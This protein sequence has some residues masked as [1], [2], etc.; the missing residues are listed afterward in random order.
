[1]EHA[2]VD[3]ADQA[4]QTQRRP[5]NTTTP[6]SIP[7]I[8]HQVAASPGE[9]LDPSTRAFMEPRFGHD[10][11]QV[12]VHTDARAAEAAHAVGALAYTTGSHVVFGAQQYAPTTHDGQRLIAHEL[13]HVV[14]QSRGPSSIQRS[15]IAPAGGR[16]E[17]EAREAASA[18]LA[19]QP[20][21]ALSAADA[22]QRQDAGPDAG[23][24]TGAP[25]D[26]GTTPDAGAT[27]APDAGAPAGPPDA[28][29]PGGTAPGAPGAPG[30]GAPPVAPPV[31]LTSLE[32]ENQRTSITY[33]TP[34]VLGAAGRDHYVTAASL[35]GPEAVVRA[36]VTPAVAASDPSV[37]GISWTMNGTALTPGSD[38]LHVS[39][40]RGAGKKVIRASLGGASRELT[41]WAV[42]ATIA[43]TGPTT[44][45]T[46]T[47]TGLSIPARIDFAATIIPASIITDADRPALEGA[48]TVD[49]PGGT[50][51]CGNALTGGVNR[52]WDMSRQIRM[53][54]IDPAG[55]LPLSCLDSVGG[56]Y[57]ANITEGN[58]DAGVADENNNPYG[59]G[60][61][62]TSFDTP[63]RFFPHTLGA[64]GDTI[65]QH[66][67]FR[68]FARLEY[69]GTWWNISHFAPW[70]FHIRI[71]KAAGR[72]VDAGTDGAQDNAGF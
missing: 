24:G 31:T 3:R 34:S 54:N 10:F 51:S 14:Q 11:G 57:P 16:L 20:V 30:V 37:A 9:V 8:V 71:R 56:A 69:H 68:E 64:N 19:N 25:P 45:T 58:D 60:G 59:N 21:P 1:M 38:P 43:G 42:F 65:E 15:A 44:P 33:P 2:A 27:P 63:T 13:A 7:P 32:V 26:A 6:A 46:D 23:A 29:A 35:S 61:Q 62:I 49:P 67:Q 12:R 39:I 55:H 48:N 53:R 22:L 18:V 72:W 70:R 28:G 41:I 66:L 4:K 40:S 17:Q 5:A 50:N 36:N 52:R 47:G